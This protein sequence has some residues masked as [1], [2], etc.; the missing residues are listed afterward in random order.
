M[1]KK[2]ISIVDGIIDV[3]TYFDDKRFHLPDDITDLPPDDLRA[4]HKYWGENYV[5]CMNK[6]SFMQ[7]KI[8]NLEHLRS[9]RYRKKFIEFKERRLA[10]DLA[11]AKAEDS[12]SVQKYDERLRIYRT[13]ESLWI[14]LMQSCDTFKAICSRDQSYREKELDHYNRRGG[15]GR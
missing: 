1:K 11:R 3:F 15:Q 4:C 2:K 12:N 13:H 14:N 8:K 9:K 5:F 10:N 7:A 6:L